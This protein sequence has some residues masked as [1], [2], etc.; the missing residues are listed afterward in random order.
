MAGE[1]LR[2]TAKLIV[3]LSKRPSELQMARGA[4]RTG[5]AL[6]SA[7]AVLSCES[8]LSLFQEGSRHRSPGPRRRR[9]TPRGSK[10]RSTHFAAQSG[11]CARAERAATPLRHQIVRRGRVRRPSGAQPTP[12]KRRG[13]ARPGR[14]W[15]APPERNYLWPHTPR[16]RTPPARVAARRAS[17]STRDPG[18]SWT[19]W[20]I[21]K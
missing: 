10:G 8:L 20:P 9:R 3:G 17:T 15:A 2:R 5:A 11:R 12:S 6:D 13:Q 14:A 7:P 1:L 4:R 16:L 19:P 18:S 21:V